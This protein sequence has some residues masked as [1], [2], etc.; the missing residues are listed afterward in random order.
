M[1]LLADGARPVVKVGSAGSAVRRLQRALTASG[2]V[3]VPAGGV[4]DTDTRA[5]VRLWQS[6]VD[7]QVTGVMSAKH[8][9]ILQSG[10]R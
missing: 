10:R 4:Y 3:S 6:A 9:E 1:T 7:L 8:W 2:H 5:A